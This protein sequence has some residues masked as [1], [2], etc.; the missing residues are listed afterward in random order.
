MFHTSSAHAY[1]DPGSGSI[2]LQILLGGLAGLAVMMK[3]FWHRILAF[4]R[5]SRNEDIGQKDS[6]DS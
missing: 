1:L 4:L 2:L 5:I 6:K 3:V